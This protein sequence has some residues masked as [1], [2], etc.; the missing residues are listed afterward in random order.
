MAVRWSRRW[1]R[2][3]RRACKQTGQNMR[4]YSPRMFL[5]Y[6]KKDRWAMPVDPLHQQRRPRQHQLFLCRKQRPCP[7]QRKI[8]RKNTAPVRTEDAALHTQHRPRRRKAG[9]GQT[10][11]WG[12]AAADD[13][14]RP[15]R[16]F[17]LC[18]FP[19]Q[20]GI[21]AEPRRYLIPY[22]RKIKMPLRSFF[23]TQDLPQTFTAAT[24]ADPHQNSP[25]TK[26]FVYF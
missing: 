18:P 21:A 3:T 26:K 19:E 5:F 15:Q 8:L 25:S 12:K 9:K 23:R 22:H 7:W 13:L 1:S 17:C 4:G 2:L 11:A 6:P 14:P 20:Q 10:T 24:H 16:S